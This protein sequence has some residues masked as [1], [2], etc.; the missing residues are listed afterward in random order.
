M[1]LHSEVKVLSPEEMDRV[2][3]GSLKVL[4]ETGVVFHSDEALEIFKENDFKVEGK[5]VFFSATQ[6]EKA[7]EQAPPTYEFCARN[8]EHTVSV[9]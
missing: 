7:L 1:A 8:P 9:G 4:E 5:T 2:H 3:Q 6:V